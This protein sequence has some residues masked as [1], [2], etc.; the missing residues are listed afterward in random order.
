M[1]V[2]QLNDFYALTSQGGIAAKREA[3]CFIS[4][5]IVLAVEGE[6]DVAAEMLVEARK[7]MIAAL[8]VDSEI[9]YYDALEEGLFPLHQWKCL[10]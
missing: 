8:N 3:D 5:A 10:E 4:Q 2:D 7:I 9:K 1:T 6:N